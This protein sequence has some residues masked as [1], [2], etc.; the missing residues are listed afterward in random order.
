MA[1]GDYMPYDPLSATGLVVT[2]LDCD[3]AIVT[4]TGFLF[5]YE[6]FPLTAAHCIPIDTTDASL[7]LIP[8]RLKR[9]STILSVVRHP[10]ADIAL[11]RG[12]PS[13]TDS[14]EGY[15]DTAFWN[16]VANW[17]LGEQFMAYGFPEETDSARAAVATPRL[18]IGHYQRFFEF[19]SPSNFHY[20]A[21]EMSV[22]APGGLSGGPVFRADAPQVV[23]GLVT[24][25][26]DSYTI[27]DSRRRSLR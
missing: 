23:M 20:T 13:G 21:G 27:D 22:P 10:T 8:S 5:R 26:H 4:G 1:K 12:E 18:F 2:G 24:T 9:V 16:C 6:H 7:A 25:N 3:Q 15:P 19:E 14:Q 11:L 17:S